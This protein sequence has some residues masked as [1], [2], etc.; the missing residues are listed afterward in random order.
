VTTNENQK[1]T[2]AT[3]NQQLSHKNKTTTTS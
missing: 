1:T 2:P 3:N